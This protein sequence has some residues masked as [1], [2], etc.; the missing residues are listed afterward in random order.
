MKRLLG[1][2][3]FIINFI[4]IGLLTINSSHADTLFFDSN[5]VTI[6][7]R[8][9]GNGEPVL[10]LH[11]YTMSSNMWQGSALLNSL[12]KNH[13]VISIDLRGHGLSDKPTTT[14][15]YGPKVGQDVIA[16]LDHL[17]IAKVHLVGFSMGSYV[18][19][20]L[21][22]S[23]PERIAT[24]TLGS[25]YFPFASEDERQY[26]EQTALHM[27]AQ[28]QQL[29]DDDEN[30][31]KRIKLLA[32]A[33]VARGWQFDAV[34][35]QQVTAITVPVQ[36]IFGS[37]EQD[38]LFAAQQYRFSLSGAAQ[39]TVIIDDADHDSE[40]AAVLRPEF[41]AAVESHISRSPL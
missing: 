21:L 4:V 2:L 6:A 29:A 34:T 24:A 23:N 15:D 22:V 26:A 14:A 3:F 35:D 1:K 7:Y 13:Q 32:L 36:A 20:R 11:G 17:N 9:V 12:A 27:I 19:G 16:L 37:E 8:Q 33:A 39:S 41:A 31:E 18:V 40:Q 5:G 28:A 25:G 30:V 38:E 10:L